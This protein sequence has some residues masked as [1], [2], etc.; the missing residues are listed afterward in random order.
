MLKLN[1]FNI[2]VKS[3]KNNETLIGRETERQKDRKTT[4]NTYIVCQK[5]GHYYV[6][7]STGIYE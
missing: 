1:L 7:F 4:K 2:S 5:F 6:G 3:L